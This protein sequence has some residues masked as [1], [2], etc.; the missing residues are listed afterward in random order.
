MSMASGFAQTVTDGPVLAAIVVSVLAGLVSFLSPCVLPLVPGYLSYVTG[1]TGSDIET[2]ERRKRWRVV[3]GSALF[4][5]GFTAVFTVIGAAIGGS[6]VWLLTHAPM[7]EKLVGVAVIVLGLG[8]LGAIPGLQREWRMRALPASGLAGAPILGA[9]FALGWV[10]CVSPTFGAVQGLAYAEGT[11]ERGIILSVAYALGLGI[12]FVL[13][14]LGLRWVAGTLA[15]V[16]RHGAW[17]TRAGGVLLIVIGLLLVTG[18]WG[19]FAIWLRSTV[20]PGEIG[21]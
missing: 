1:L 19:D 13:V 15:F 4:V 17:V 5:A 12:P 20:G 2:E 21:I 18:W 16:R 6:S 9:V 10:P 8:Y 14:A 3:A 11:A 7:F